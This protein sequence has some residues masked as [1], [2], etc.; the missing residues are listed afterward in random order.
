MIETPPQEVSAAP[1]MP[2]ILTPK[3][4]ERTTRKGEVLI[5]GTVGLDVQKVEVTRYIGDKAESYILQKYVPFSGKWSYLAAAFYGNFVAGENRFTV[6][7]I[8]KDGK[9]AFPLKLL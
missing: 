1:E 2:I 4:E 8:G 7:A 3:A 6:V 5:S 9:K